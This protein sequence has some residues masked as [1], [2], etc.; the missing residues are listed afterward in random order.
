MKHARI[1]AAVATAALLA[2]CGSSGGGS[3]SSTQAAALYHKLGQ[4]I[5]SHGLPDF[6]D[7]VQ[8]P[9]TGSWGLPQGTATPPQY[10]LNDCKS[11]LNQIAALGTQN[12]QIPASDL[13]SYQKWAQCMRQ[14]GIPNWPDPNPNG[15]FTLPPSLSVA[16]VRAGAYNKQ[17]EACKKYVPAAGIHFLVNSSPG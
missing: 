4:C 14:H 1:L 12:N 9:Q 2:G 6:P 13:Q 10:V 17:Q 15:T 3:G 8:D 11:V 7:P 5:R 16:S